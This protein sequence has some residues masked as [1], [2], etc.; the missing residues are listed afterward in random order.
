MNRQRDLEEAKAQGPFRI[1]LKPEGRRDKRQFYAANSNGM[2][3]T[4]IREVARE[5]DTL[6]LAEN[7]TRRLIANNAKLRGRVTVVP[8]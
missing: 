2:F 1:L 6:H 5:F 3:W 7:I 8:V 4:Q